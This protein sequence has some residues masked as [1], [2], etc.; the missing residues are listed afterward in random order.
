MTN[1][2]ADRYQFWRRTYFLATRILL[3]MK[4]CITPHHTSVRLHQQGTTAI[5][6][7]CED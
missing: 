7:Y 4:I 2:F 1:F 6:P 5:L 3:A